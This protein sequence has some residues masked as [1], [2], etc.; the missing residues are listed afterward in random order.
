MNEVS[1]KIKAIIVS[2]GDGT[3]VGGTIPKQYQKIGGIPILALTIRRFA[4]LNIVDEIIV[5]ISKI[6]QEY[7]DTKIMPLLTKKV[8]ITYGGNTRQD[9]V[10]EGLKCTEYN[11]LV[12]IHDGARPFVSKELIKNIIYKTK[13]SG[14]ASPG[15]KATDTLWRVRKNVVLKVENRRNVFMAQTPQGFFNKDII[16]NYKSNENY[17]NDDVELAINNGLK[18]EIIEG[19]EKNIKITTMAHINQSNKMLKNQLFVKTGIGYD[20]HAFEKGTELILCGLKIPFSK[21]LKGHSDADV[22]MHAITDAIYGAIAE[23]DIGTWFP[24]DNPKWK[25]AKSK[26]FL[27]HASK[28]VTEKGYMISN[29]DCTIICEEPKIQ[30]HA[31]KMIQYLS[32]VLLIDEERISVKATTNE[33]L[34]YIGRKEGI[35]AQAIAT[36]L[37]ND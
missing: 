7:F 24:P 13:E 11:D 6:H 31:Q 12:L 22:A 34:G 25:N 36:V 1:L 27:D 8:T 30:P 21:S 16:N 9:S 20:V 26:I 18:V 17:A 3:R 28:L 2:A 4:E 33:K 15:I 10:Y 29:I 32:E 14:A 5:V 23:G 19:E 35:A 37:K